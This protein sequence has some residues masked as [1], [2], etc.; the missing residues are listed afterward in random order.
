MMSPTNTS[1]GIV[2]LI[3]ESNSHH[4]YVSDAVSAGAPFR[5]ALAELD[6]RSHPL[7]VLKI[8]TLRELFP[9]FGHEGSVHPFSPYLAKPTPTTP[10]W[11]TLLWLIHS[12]GSTSLPK[13]VSI[14][15]GHVAR[16]RGC[17]C[18]QYILRLNPSS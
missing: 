12:S 15:E 6:R 9:Y 4:V 5:D 3:L 8:P 1:E 14:H 13:V 10:S 17:Y 2:H 11:D 7:N 16:I 18:E